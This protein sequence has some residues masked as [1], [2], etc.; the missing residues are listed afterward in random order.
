M[1]MA[2]PPEPKLKT[3]SNT[4]SFE[5]ETVASKATQ[6]TSIE[7]SDTVLSVDTDDVS[8][9]AMKEYEVVLNEDNIT[10][11]KLVAAV[12]ELEEVEVGEAEP[13][14][15]LEN[16]SSDFLPIGTTK[17][18]EE[19]EEKVG[20]GPKSGVIQPVPQN[21]APSKSEAN[22]DDAHNAT[23]A[24]TG[25]DVAEKKPIMQ[26]VVRSPT[27]TSNE[28]NSIEV[29]AE[30]EGKA[31]ESPAHVFVVGADGLGVDYDNEHSDSLRK[32]DKEPLDS[33]ETK[34]RKLSTRIKKILGKKLTTKL[35]R[36][37]KTKATI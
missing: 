5:V 19:E 27:G 11:K 3:I 32:S 8:E 28:G 13:K 14:E 9:H 29:V 6:D 31:A 15:V 22:S 18:D 30:K 10:R 7:T 37:K 36:K 23:V 25:E 34:S 4:E 16:A 12:P 2:V 35:T 21:E 1:H 33:K 24:A 26:E 17:E 20:T